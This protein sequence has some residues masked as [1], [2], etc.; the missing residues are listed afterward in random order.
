M[1]DWRLAKQLARKDKAIAEASEGLGKA[2]Q[3]ASAAERATL[4]E[5]RRDHR[6]QIEALNQLLELASSP[7][8]SLYMDRARAHYNLNDLYECIADAGRALKVDPDDTGALEL[9]GAAYYRLAEH[10]MAKNHWQQ[11]LKRDPEHEGCR[12]GYKLVRS[13]AKKDAAGDDHAKMGRHAEAIKSWREAIA[14]DPEHGKYCHLAQLKIAR[15]ALALKE[16]GAAVAAA[17][18]AIELDE[19]A[20]D[21]HLLKCEA[22][23][24]AEDYEGAVRAAKR[25]REL[26]DNDTTKKMQAKA[27][28]ALKQSKTVNYYKVL[29]VR[30]DSSSKEIK[31]AYR[32]LALKHHP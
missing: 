21:A 23:M 14:V 18:R 16:H 32:D 17:D 24:N 20:V 19:A 4:A 10:E 2:E 31:K 27:E 29:G 11:A 12:Q 15:A 13:L 22:L 7:S 26:R 5:R 1:E 8:A 9:R 6:G 3:C 30:R 25:A 28:A